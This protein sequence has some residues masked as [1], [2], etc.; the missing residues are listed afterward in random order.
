MHKNAAGKSRGEIIKQIREQEESV[1]DFANYIPIGN[2]AEKLQ[3]WSEQGAEILYL[4]ALTENKKARGDEIVGKEGLKAD[5]EILEKN[6]FPKGEVYH[7]EDG[8][9]YGDIVIR[10]MPDV[11]IED[12]CE[13]IGGEIEMVSAQLGP[14]IKN[15]IKSII[16]KEFVGIDHLTDDVNNLI[17]YAG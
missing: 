6:H 10:V 5:A 1:R 2:A 14:Q 13:S 17:H 9:S 16:V 7:R 12:D 4:S 3:K 15:K 11:L 8:E